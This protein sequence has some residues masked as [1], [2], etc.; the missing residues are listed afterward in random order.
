MKKGFHCEVILPKSVTH[1]FLSRYNVLELRYLVR[2]LARQ[3]NFYKRNRNSS[4]LEKILGKPRPE[5]RFP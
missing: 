5:R 2:A 3:R 4:L 1:E